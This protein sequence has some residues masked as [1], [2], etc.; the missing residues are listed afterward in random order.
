M[1]EEHT[2][3]ELTRIRMGSVKSLAKE[4]GWSQSKTR[5]MV[6]GEQEPTSGEMRELANALGLETPEEI[7]A[8]FRL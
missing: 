8:V 6:S 1:R 7:A 5:R 2:L 4:M 3:K